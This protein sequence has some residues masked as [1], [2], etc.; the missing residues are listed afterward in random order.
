MAFAGVSYLPHVV[1][2]EDYPV[3]VQDKV[4]GVGSGLERFPDLGEAQA[5]D[6]AAATQSPCIP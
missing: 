1:T 5:A 3:H 4:V 6:G 2:V